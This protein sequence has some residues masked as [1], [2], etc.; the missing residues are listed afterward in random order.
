M[1]NN[2]DTMIYFRPITV[3]F[4]TNA[5]N[6]SDMSTKMDLVKVKYELG[7]KSVPILNFPL[8]LGPFWVQGE[9]C[10]E[11]HLHNGFFYGRI[12][13]IGQIDDPQG[14]SSSHHDS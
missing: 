10:A 13:A 8:I 14:E 6:M 5:W 7:S 2:S 11:T 1:V 9:H 4:L 12:N 3:T